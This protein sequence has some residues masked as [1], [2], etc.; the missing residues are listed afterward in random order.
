[1]PLQL[2]EQLSQTRKDLRN[3]E[4]SLKKV[5]E[6]LSLREDLAAQHQTELK[7]RLGK[8]AAAPVE[9]DLDR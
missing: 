7:E 9:I 6:E 3:L 8:L 5:R 1:M 4:G 2:K